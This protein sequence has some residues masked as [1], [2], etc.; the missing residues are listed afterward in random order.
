MRPSHFLLLVTT[1]FGISAGF[2]IAGANAQPASKVSLGDL[3]IEHRAA[4]VGIDAK[5]PRFSWR[6]HGSA[7]G[8]RQTAYQIQVARSADS[9][10]GAGKALSWDS[11]WVVSDQ[12][13]LVA[14]AGEPLRSSTP[15]FWRLRIKDEGGAT[16]SWSA[17]SRWVTG[18]LDADK[19][20][21]AD[22]IGFDQ[23]FK[24]LPQG[25]E[26]FD[27]GQAKWICHPGMEKE[28]F[29]TAFYRKSFELPKGTTRVM[30]GMEA[31]F[32]AQFFVN[33]VEVF[34][35]GRF[36]DVPSYLDVTPWIRPGL[37]QFAFRVYQCDSSAHAGLIASLRIEQADGAVVRLFTD[38]TWESTNKPVDLWSDKGH[39]GEGWGPVN[40]LGKPGEPNTT[41]QSKPVLFSPLFGDKVFLPPPVYL[42]KEIDLSKPVR[43]AVF[44]GTAQGLYDLHVNGRRLTPSGFQPGWTQFDRRISYVS[45]DVTD[46]LKPG[47]NA[48][49]A[50]LADGWFRGNLIWTGREMFGTKIR[51]SGQL[52]VE[53][54]DG[55]RESFRTDPTWKASFGPTL[56][57][58][59]M[60]G[61]IYDARNELPGW[62]KVGFDEKGWSA[63][64]V[65]VR[66]SDALSASKLDVTARVRELIAQSKPVVANNS[67]VGG[68][69]V[70]PKIQKGLRVF[71]Q[72]NGE[73]K[74]A[75]IKEPSTWAL[76]AG[77]KE[78]DV[79]RAIFGNLG[80][81]ASFIQRAHPAENV[82]PQGELAAQSITEPKPGVYVVDFGQNFAGWVRLK[83]AGR[84]G[85]SIYLRFAEDT[86][87][88][89]TIYTD[90]LRGINPADR[91]ICKGGGSESWEPRFTYHGFRYVQI[92]GLSEKPTKETVVGIVAHSG[93]PITST[94]S[95]SSPML[96]RL[97]KNVTWSQ[98]SNYFETMTDCPQRDER[99]GWV[100][101]AHFFLRSSSYNQNGASFFNK[102]FLDCLDTQGKNGNIRDGAPGYSPGAGSALLDWT[103]ATMITP[104]VIWQQ[105]GD[106]Q[107]IIAH[108]DALRLYMTLWQQFASDID[109][110]RVV[111][112][113]GLADWLVGD[114]C[115]LQGGTTKALLG[116]VF[117]YNLSLQ[118]AEYARITKHEE[119]V[120]TFTDLAAHFREEIISKHIAPDGTV[121]G[122]TQTGYALLTRFHIYDPAQEPLLRKKFQDRMLADK[123]GVMTGFHGT[124]NLLQG[125]SSIGL[126]Q[127]AA[128]TVLSEEYP[129]WGNMVKLG[130]TTIWEHWDGKTADGKWQN[131]YMNSFNHYTFGGCG[132]WLMGWLVGLRSESPGF[133]TIRVEP[134][135]IP[136]LTWVSGS[137]ESPYGTISN[138]WERKDGR[139]T[140]RLVVP[141]NTSARVILPTSAKGV[142]L[143]GKPLVTPPVAG[144]PETSVG[145]GTHEFAWT[146]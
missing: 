4:P 57:S 116:R 118:M 18:L 100:G 37:N 3:L 20:L 76:P 105:Y 64:D 92:L 130:A 111:K 47:R 34:Q 138:R 68:V 66:P 24:G 110:G 86:R 93:D 137:F 79:Q 122:D 63:V 124:G 74:I 54:E 129:G 88:D 113:G 103:A 119:D 32:A 51:F 69:D 9:L 108:Y 35:G 120:K 27:I 26:W 96:D 1:C 95:S 85:Q 44:H 89:G 71:Y 70:C 144:Y 82:R 73:E 65:T 28:K 45:T 58:D 134:N 6:L 145:S 106:A 97:Y 55:S 43:F 59:I 136:E 8:L 84:A 94:F 31:N 49:G 142:V 91:Y 62:D 12:C 61:E 11:G 140:M 133:K 60:Q 52:E 117:G 5:V 22:W 29:G 53:Y 112:Q 141:P 115:A 46:A 10:E 30:M 139:V 128:K 33:G 75:T 90:N 7:N 42:R 98:R 127:E 2:G 50:V 101:D 132:E 19:E 39:S 67:L 114:W 25:V 131:P 78:S 72:E 83:V 121:T 109:T 143:Q 16:S 104:W 135:V 15:Y 87:P 41:G 14:Y 40:V 48:I 23:R 125:L 56:Q 99:L 123:F 36:N 38:E 21:L 17:P 77:L 107:P 102:W 81:S 80:R 126:E 146:E 13:H